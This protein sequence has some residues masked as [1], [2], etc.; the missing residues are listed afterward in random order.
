MPATGISRGGS[1]W[2]TLDSVGIAIS[3]LEKTW[4]DPH[5]LHE[6]IL[7]W[8]RLKNHNLFVSSKESRVEARMESERPG[9]LHVF[10]SFLSLPFG[11]SKEA[12]GFG[13]VPSPEGQPL[14]VFLLTW[15][16]SRQRLLIHLTFLA[17][18]PKTCKKNGSRH[19]CIF[20]NIRGGK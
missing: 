7:F 9:C 10:C 16:C 4:P 12:Y 2:E 17:R 6:N 15:Q 5:E 13:T 18:I 11:G 3:G 14:T 19:E 20:K 1:R 8:N